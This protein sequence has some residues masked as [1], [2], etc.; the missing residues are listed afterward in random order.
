MIIYAIRILTLST[1]I[2]PKFPF[3]MIH[4]MLNSSLFCNTSVQYV[5]HAL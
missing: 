5:Q 2:T 1:G 3:K 4:P